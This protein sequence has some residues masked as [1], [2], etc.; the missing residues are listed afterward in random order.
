MGRPIVRQLDHIFASIADPRG[1]FDAFTKLGFPPAW[2]VVETPTFK[3]GGLFLANLKIEF[4]YFEGDVFNREG[5]PLA[6]TGLAFEP[7]PLD[8]AVP[9][10]DRRGLDHTDLYHLGS[11]TNCFITN[12]SPSFYTFLCEYHL[13]KY[14]WTDLIEGRNP[15]GAGI[16]SVAERWDYYRGLIDAGQNGALGV[17]AAKEVT[18]GTSDLATANRQWQLLLEPVKPDSR[19]AWQVGN[20]PAIRLVEHA[21]DAILDLKLSVTSLERAAKH[22]EHL[23]ALKESGEAE[24]V[25]DADAVWG[26]DLRL[27]QEAG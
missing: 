3:S 15:A 5:A 22:L 4:A 12:I 18:I 20:G 27:V 14:P 7:E 8:Q 23:S 17:V 21:S 13:E 24:L 16:R 1:P 2:P 6:F 25:I 19:G 11:W 10:L 26:L 9:E